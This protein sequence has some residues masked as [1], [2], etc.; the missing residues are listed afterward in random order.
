MQGKKIYH[1][2]LFVSFRLSEHVPENNFYRRLKKI[3]DLRFLYELTKNYYG[4]RKVNT[5]GIKQANKIML[6]AA[7]AYNLKK[8]L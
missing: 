2:K 1:E 4:M 8:L 3:L 7:T 5:K 6:T